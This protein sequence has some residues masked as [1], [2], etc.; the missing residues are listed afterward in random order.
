MHITPDQKLH[1]FQN[2]MQKFNGNSTASGLAISHL[3]H[4]SFLS[5]FCSMV[6]SLSIV[7]VELTVGCDAQ[8]P[9]DKSVGWVLQSPIFQVDDPEPHQAGCSE[10]SEVNSV[11]Y[12]SDLNNV[13][14]LSAFLLSF[15][16]VQFSCSVMSDSLRPLESQH[17]RPPCPSPT[18][19]VH[20]DSC[21][22]SR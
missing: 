10:I 8:Q 14:L 16:S 7:Q 21:P 4:L 17:A 19:G 6:S 9:G 5:M 3:K 12:S 2:S 15:S 20:S 11:A 22:L 13:P 18:P 1:E